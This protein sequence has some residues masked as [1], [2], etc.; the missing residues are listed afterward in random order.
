MPMS[1]RLPPPS[2]RTYLRDAK[3]RLY[4]EESQDLVADWDETKSEV[5]LRA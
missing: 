3:N 2:S 5:V 1:S 4:D